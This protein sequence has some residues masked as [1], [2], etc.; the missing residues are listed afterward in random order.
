MRAT[1]LKL[2]L[3]VSLT[4]TT[5]AAAQQPVGKILDLFKG[6]YRH[7]AAIMKNK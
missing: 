3:I 7:I 6:I 2:T 1:F 4:I 5:S